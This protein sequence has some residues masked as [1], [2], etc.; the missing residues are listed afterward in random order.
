MNACYSKIRQKKKITNWQLHNVLNIAFY[1]CHLKH[2][3][4]SSNDA[5]HISNTEIIQKIFF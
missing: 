4:I 5:D 2:I 1:T 3:T